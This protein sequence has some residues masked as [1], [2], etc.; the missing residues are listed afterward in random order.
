VILISL[1]YVA[2]IIFECG[3]NWKGNSNFIRQWELLETKIS[4]N[5][6]FPQT[7]EMPRISAT[8]EWNKK[9]IKELH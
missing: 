6:N 1:P 3:R 4:S 8:I 5:F 9:L 2:P 7:S